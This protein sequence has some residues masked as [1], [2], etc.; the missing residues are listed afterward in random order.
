MKLNKYHFTWYRSHNYLKEKEETPEKV[1]KELKSLTLS[2]SKR[3][4]VLLS[5]TKELCKKLKEKKIDFILLKGLS[6]IKQAKENESSRFMV[7]IDLLVK[8]KELEKITSALKDYNIIK[9]N[10]N[11]WR[12]WKKYYG[13]HEPV[14]VKSKN[15]QKI[16]LEIHTNIVPNIN[17]FKIKKELLWENISEIRLKKEKLKSFN[18]ELQIIYLCIQTSFHNKFLQGLRNL[19]DIDLIITNNKINWGRIVSL[20]LET[21]TQEFVYVTLKT[22]KKLLSTTIPTDVLTKLRKQSNFRQIKRIEKIARN[23]LKIHNFPKLIDWKYNI[24]LAKDFRTK[25]KVI[26]ISVKFLIEKIIQNK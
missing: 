13:H 9:T 15:N 8:K 10:K 12:N 2:N 20:S 24:I 14:L 26:I 11:Y 17:P 7:D 4:L 5:E 19:K 18:L 16:L 22:T 21:K 1:K 3:N 6:I 23:V 25:L